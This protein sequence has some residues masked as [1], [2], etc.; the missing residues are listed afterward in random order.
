MIKTPEF[1]VGLTVLAAGAI[2]IGGIMWGTRF[3]LK[4][5]RYTL[6]AEFDTAYGLDDED[7]VTIY[8]VRQGK[9]T[10]V[11]L[12]KGHVLVTMALFQRFPLPQ[13]SRLY[14]KNVGL[15]GERFIAIEPGTSAVL[16]DP[17]VPIQ[18]LNETSISDVFGGMGGLLAKA[19]Q[20]LA[21]LDRLVGD[22]QMENSI[23]QSVADIQQ[24]V[25]S[26]SGMVAN[27]R[28]SLTATI[29]DFSQS[30][31][32]LK[33]VVGGREEQLGR[34]LD[35]F[36]TTSEKL[37]ATLEQL[38]ELSASLKGITAK[39]ES[40]ESTLGA[41]VNS[42]QLYN[43]LL[44]SVEHLDALVKDVRENPGKYTK[45]LKLKIF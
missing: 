17:A 19:E 32:A 25:R 14:I 42:R 21:R 12:K 35:N 24:L 29:R 5:D 27:S 9:V 20:T 3:K 13:D 33:N 23:K 8:G 31:Q 36:A 16:L 34:T 28:G 41:V 45:G 26:L 10:A 4:S 6:Q 1:K 38:E 44:E 39:V 18:G 37:N 15:M 30:A 22:E 7:P 2:L 43:R 11:E 40:E